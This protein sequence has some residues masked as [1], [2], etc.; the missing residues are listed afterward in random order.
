MRRAL[1]GLL[2]LLMAQPALAATV[3][4]DGGCNNNG[5]GTAIDCASSGG[6]NGPFNKIEGVIGPSEACSNTYVVRG[7]HTAASHSDSSNHASGT[8]DGRY[9]GNEYAI[10]VDCASGTFPLI[11]PHN[12]G[13]GQERVYIDGT[14]CPKPSGCTGTN[15]DYSATGDAA[16][17]GTSGTAG[18]WQQ[19]TWDGTNCDCDAVRQNIQVGAANSTACTET[20]WTTDAGTAG[21]GFQSGTAANVL[22]A[23]KDDGSITYGTGG[24]NTSC[25]GSGSPFACCTG[26]GTGTCDLN[27]AACVGSGNPY[28]CCTGA[29]A[30]TCLL[31]MTNAHGSYNDDRCT[32]SADS[33]QKWMPCTTNSDCLSGETCS[34]NV[35]PEI[36]HYRDPA[37]NVLYVRWGTGSQA[38]GTAKRPYVSYTGAG[39]G[40]TY[41]KQADWVKIQGFDFRCHRHAAIYSDGDQD[42]IDR[43]DL[44]ALD[45]RVFFNSDTGGSDYGMVFYRANRA[46]ISG[47]EIAYTNSEG[48]HCNSYLTGTA[49][50]IKIQNNHIHDQGNQA[51]M[52]TAMT[53]GTPVGITC[54]PAE[55]SGATRGNMTG[56][57]ISGNLI[58]DIKARPDQ[59]ST[60]GIRME[61]CVEGVKVHD[62]YL[63]RAGNNQGFTID[64]SPQGNCA[65][66]CQCKNASSSGQE[67][68]NNFIVDQGRECA[69]VF[70]YADVNTTNTISTLSYYNNSCINPGLNGGIVSGTF[71]GAFSNNT[72]RNNL[73]LSGSSLKAINIAAPGS[74]SGNTLSNAAMETG[75]AT[76]VTWLG[77]GYNCAS[78]ASGCSGNC[79]N[80]LCSSSAGYLALVSASDYHLTTSSPAKDAGTSTGMPSGRTTDICNSLASAHGLPSYNDCQAA[81]GTVDI[82]AD[83]FTG[84]AGTIIRR[85]A[86]VSQ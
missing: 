13:A 30:G 60:Y 52:G 68:Y 16:K 77:T 81:S 1:T 7:V 3:Y 20:W 2:A 15:C 19:C 61:H 72:I 58:V 17:C 63:L 34:A 66:T 36:D 44:F 79:S 55:D 70:T 38:P 35:S 31:D 50:V 8:F 51:V 46:T 73:F 83:E 18:A 23:Q 41:K 86:V 84:A 54:N 71:S 27:N 25:S 57:E 49:S 5:N 69:Q 82:G 85:R 14:R 74:G 33:N 43:G 67:W 9:F 76:P 78:V 24:F 62:N 22:W 26:S 75:N 37:N 12:Y 6:G 42:A 47:N 40:F 45:N 29:D 39:T 56:S 4:I 48:V 28:A 65:G 64:A 11:N 59:S 53:A 80:S 32:N 21:T 10:D